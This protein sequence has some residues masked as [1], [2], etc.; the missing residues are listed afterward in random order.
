MTELYFSDEHAITSNRNTAEDRRQNHARAALYSTFRR[1][2]ATVRRED[3]VHKQQYLDIHEP[4]VVLITAGVLLLSIF[5]SVFTLRLLQMGSEE[6]NP[7]MDYFIQRDT[8][9]FFAAK[10]LMT[11]SCVVFLVMH[12]KFRLFNTISG[13]HML[14]GTFA[15]YVC[16]VCYEISMLTGW[17]S[18][19]LSSF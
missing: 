3:E 8:N 16:L 13:Y 1:R 9:L 2:R 4:W 10:F 18:Y 6:L 11:A 12:K 14:I 7:V 17:A 5:D 15:M 19:L